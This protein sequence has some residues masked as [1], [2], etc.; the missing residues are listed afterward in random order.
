M[1]ITHPCLV[2]MGYPMGG[3][4][5]FGWNGLPHNSFKLS[6]VH[7]YAF[8]WFVVLRE[9][10]IVKMMCKTFVIEENFT[11]KMEAI[12]L[13]DDGQNDVMDEDIEDHESVEKTKEKE[14]EDKEKIKKKRVE[15]CRRK[16]KRVETGESRNLTRGIILYLA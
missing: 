4:P 8:K 7:R 14:E 15:S 6:S 5:M 9:S 1:A 2:G 11:N 10:A 13:N 3:P 12:D 16:K